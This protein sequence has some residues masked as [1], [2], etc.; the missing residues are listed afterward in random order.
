MKKVQ[1]L[2]LISL[3]VGLSSE[4]SIGLMNSDF[5]ISAAVIFFQAFIIYYEDLRIIPTGLLSGFTVYI[6]RLISYYLINGSI[7]D[8]VFSYQLEIVFYI[9]YAIIFSILTKN[10]NKKSLNYLFL[11]MI[12]SDFSGNLLEVI[13][14]NMTTDTLSPS[15]IGFT[16]LIVSVVRSSIVW[17]ILNGIKYYGML[18]VKEEHENRYKKLLWL[19]SQLRT[20]MYWIE[21]NMDNIE[22][23]MSKSYKL[24]EKIKN[25]VDKETWEEGALNIARDVHEIKKEN[26]LIFRGLKSITE[27]ELE[28]KGMN[29]KDIISILSETMKREIK[30]L[31][32]DIRLQLSIEHN[33]YTS[34][35]YYLMSILRNLVMNSIDAIPKSKKG[36]KI[37]I[38]QW[39]KED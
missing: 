14:R 4:I 20:E 25:N 5:R 2:I 7:S 38:E 11:I 39:L 8:V 21:K 37:T 16:L 24:Y 30:E 28:D 13:I 1:K 18:I 33:F 10:R 26:H 35:H 31:G 6:F 29:I 17:L 27:N 19:T 23:I 36:G 3:I 9:F 34:K 12:I 32:K 15:K 22:E